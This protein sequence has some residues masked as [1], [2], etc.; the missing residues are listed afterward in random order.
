MGRLHNL[1]PRGASRGDR[2]GVDLGCGVERDAVARGVHVALEA[3]HLAVW[4]ADLVLPGCGGVGGHLDTS[5]RR[6]S[7]T[8]ARLNNSRKHSPVVCTSPHAVCGAYCGTPRNSAT[9]ARPGS[10]VGSKPR[11]PAA[12]ADR[13]DRK[14]TR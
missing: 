4:P 14:S 5:A 6:A 9:E 2:A 3:G 11:T 7:F 12:Y 13:S 10:T 1:S 8:P